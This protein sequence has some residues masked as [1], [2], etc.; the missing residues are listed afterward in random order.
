[1][2]GDVILVNGDL[3]NHGAA[4]LNARGD[5][6][7]ETSIESDCCPLSSLVTLMMDVCP[8]IHCIRDAT[9]G[10]VATVLNEF[11]QSANCCIRLSEAEL[12]IRQ[13]VQAVCEILGLDPL[14]MANEGKL[15]AVVPGKFGQPLLEAMRNHTYGEHAAIIG[16]V[17]ES[18]K[19][20]VVLETEF[21]GER[22]IDMLVGEQLPRIC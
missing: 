6:A 12:P 16:T 19:G 14:Y 11:A 3:G 17:A 4:V 22:L 21:G 10:G 18:P 15:V 7:L 9:R 2:S 5:L 8:D 13:D 1:M 20:T